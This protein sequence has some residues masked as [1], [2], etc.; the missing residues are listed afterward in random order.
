MR[1]PMYS[2][3]GI[4]AMAPCIICGICHQQEFWSN[5]V[6][7]NGILWR[8]DPPVI[9]KA[10]HHSWS[11]TFWKHIT[12]Q[13]ER[14]R[15]TARRTLMNG[16]CMVCMSLH[17]WH[18][19]GVHWDPFLHYSASASNISWPWN[20]SAAAPAVEDKANKASVRGV[21]PRISPANW[22][23]W[24]LLKLLSKLERH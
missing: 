3:T 22:E 21:H 16:V 10:W 4:G 23:Y 9:W 8:S 14:E 12:V 1:W 24:R 19:C 2:M 17:M 13:R 11:C 7:E 20:P 18:I 6:T 15:D 5:N